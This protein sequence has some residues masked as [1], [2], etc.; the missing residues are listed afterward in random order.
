MALSTV[1][2]VK[3]TCH[4]HFQVYGSSQ[5][6]LLTIISKIWCFAIKCS[7]ETIDFCYPEVYSNSYGQDV[8][9]SHVHHKALLEIKQLYYQLMKLRMIVYNHYRHKQESAIN[10]LVHNVFPES[11]HDVEFKCLPIPVDP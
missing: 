9:H 4:E 11:I 7:L 1:K 3:I 10:K 5:Y 2:S 6:Q 8:R